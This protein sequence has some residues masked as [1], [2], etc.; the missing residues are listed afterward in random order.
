MGLLYLMDLT[1]NEGI[2]SSMFVQRAAKK[3]I[4]FVALHKDTVV[5]GC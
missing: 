1:T 5:G 3:D 4:S 2:M